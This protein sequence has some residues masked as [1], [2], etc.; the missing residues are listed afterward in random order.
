MVSKSARCHVK[1][2][3]MYHSM[4]NITRVTSL[5]DTDFTNGIKQKNMTVTQGY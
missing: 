2:T 3:L 4:S 1:Y 5:K